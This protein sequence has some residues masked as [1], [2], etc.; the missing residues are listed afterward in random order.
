MDVKLIGKVRA[1]HVECVDMV[2]DGKLFTSTIPE[3]KM[4]ILR[5]MTFVTYGALA[6]R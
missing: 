5:V 6:A 1:A 4:I 2:I 3:N